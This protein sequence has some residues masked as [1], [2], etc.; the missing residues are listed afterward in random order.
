METQ[1]LDRDP[2]PARPRNGSAPAPAA[3]AAPSSGLV[4]DDLLALG[5]DELARLYAGASVPRIADVRGDLRGRMLALPAL[6]S[7]RVAMMIRRFASSSRFPWRG[8]S[9]MPDGEERGE[10]INR[11]FTDR[12][13]IYK[14]DTFIGKSRA[15]EFDAIQ[16]DYD[17]PDNP[18]FIRAIKDEIRELSPGLYLGQ[19]WLQIGTRPPVLALYFGLTSPGR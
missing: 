11:V 9:F 18:F 7:G 2:V 13:R 16:L 8:K 5:P 1:S 4:L 12:T 14:F 19:A 17:R 6:A 10:G 3:S 15:G